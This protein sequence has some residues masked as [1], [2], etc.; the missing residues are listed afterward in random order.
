METMSELSKVGYSLKDGYPTGQLTKS[1]WDSGFGYI[2]VDLTQYTRM[3]AD[4]DL[5]KTIRVTLTNAS[6]LPMS[7]VAMVFVEKEIDV[8]RAKG[9][10]DIKL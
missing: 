1:E 8:N 2:V 10:I 5:S 3:S 4:D 7:Y 6:R 9:G